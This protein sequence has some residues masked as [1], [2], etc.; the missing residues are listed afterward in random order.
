MNLVYDYGTPTISRLTGGFVG[1]VRTNYKQ[2]KFQ[3]YPRARVDMDT[4]SESEEEDSEEGDRAP[5][6]SQKEYNR[7]E[8]TQ[9]APSRQ[10]SQPYSKC[11][12]NRDH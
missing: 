2:F 11:Q 10:R 7:Q 8:P 12:S 5:P 9:P 4:T 6:Y 3:K 1:G